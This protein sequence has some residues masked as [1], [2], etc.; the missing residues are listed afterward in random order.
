Y[1]LHDALPIFFSELLRFAGIG[2]SKVETILIDLID[3]QTN[4]TIAPLAGT[5]EVNIRLTANGDTKQACEKRIAQVKQEILSRIG[6]YYYGSDDITLEASFMDNMTQ[7]F[8]IYDG[9]IGRAH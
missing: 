1:S 5:H 8:A 9:E 6:K 4:P 7:S 2:E 3:K